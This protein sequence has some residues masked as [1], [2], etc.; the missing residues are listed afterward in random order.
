MMHDHYLLLISTLT[1]HV[2]GFGTVDSGHLCLSGYSEVVLLRRLPK[3][4]DRNAMINALGGEDS[5]KTSPLSDVE[6]NICL[7][8]CAT[9][10][11]G[12]KLCKWPGKDEILRLQSLQ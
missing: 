5:S 6:V 4:H 10:Q 3:G 1:A 9:S 7:M 2:I 8:L 11:G 12:M